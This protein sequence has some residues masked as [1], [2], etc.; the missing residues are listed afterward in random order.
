MEVS[1]PCDLTT[2]AGACDGESVSYQVY[3]PSVGLGIALRTGLEAGVHIRPLV[4]QIGARYSESVG[5]APGYF[6]L[7]ISIGYFF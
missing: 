3:N 7:P 2:V 1:Q 4:L 5:G 6:S